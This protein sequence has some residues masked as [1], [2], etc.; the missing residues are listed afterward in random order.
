MCDLRVPLIYIRKAVFFK[1][2]MFRMN[3][4]LLC[5]TKF[6]VHA[7]QGV[8]DLLKCLYSINNKFILFTHV[9]LANANVFPGVGMDFSLSSMASVIHLFLKEAHIVWLYL[10]LMFCIFLFIFVY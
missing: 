8:L 3:R 9:L 10:T 4:G 6:S 1:S 2:R 5:H 7:P